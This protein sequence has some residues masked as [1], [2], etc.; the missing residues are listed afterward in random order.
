MLEHD[1]SLTL[2]NVKVL[3]LSEEHRM[4]LWL[5][6]SYGYYGTVTPF[7]MVEWRLTVGGSSLRGRSYGS[8]D[9][10]NEGFLLIQN[11][12]TKH[13]DPDAAPVGPYWVQLNEQQREELQ[14]WA[15]QMMEKGQL[16]GIVHEDDGHIDLHCHVMSRNGNAYTTYLH[17]RMNRAQ[18]WNEVEWALSNSDAPAFWSSLYGDDASKFINALLAKQWAPLSFYEHVMLMRGEPEQLSIWLDQQMEKG[19]FAGL[20][21]PSDDELWSRYYQTVR[22]VAKYRNQNVVFANLTAEQ[23]REQL[24]RDVPEAAQLLEEDVKTRGGATD[25]ERSARWRKRHPEAAREKARRYAEKSRSTPEGR[26]T[27]QAIDREYRARKA[28]NMTE[29]ERE[30]QRAL[31]RERVRRH[32][33]KKA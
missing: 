23:A 15:D 5:R 1:G 19:N 2:H 17:L 18:G 30:R 16:R 24:F 25:A 26:A 10:G 3:Y 33:A 13:T 4:T 21:E 20:A 31:V 28:A 6:S 32:R 7:T 8:V 22:W 29:E 12:L 14:V 11:L 27:K 9:M